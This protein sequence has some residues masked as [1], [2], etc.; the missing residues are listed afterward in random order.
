MGLVDRAGANDHAGGLV[1][2]NFF[3]RDSNLAEEVDVAIFVADSPNTKVLHN[4]IISRGSYPNAIEYRFA[5][6]TACRSVTISRMAESKPVT[7]LPQR[8]PATICQRA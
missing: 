5:A 1:S 6:T 2:N 3:Y 8:S 4:T 7:A